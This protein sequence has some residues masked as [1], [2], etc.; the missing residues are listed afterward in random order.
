[1][2]IDA[3]RA[4]SDLRRRR[5][6]VAGLLCRSDEALME[7]LVGSIN[8][9]SL[10]ATLVRSYYLDGWN[11]DHSLP[12]M[13]RASQGRESKALDLGGLVLQVCYHRLAAAGSDDSSMRHLFD[14]LGRE[15]GSS[16]GVALTPVVEPL[17]SPLA[18]YSPRSRAW[19]DSELVNVW[20]KGSH[21]ELDRQGLIDYLDVVGLRGLLN[22]WF[23]VEPDKLSQVHPLEVLS[24]LSID[25]D[26][27]ESMVE[28]LVRQACCYGALRE[29]AKAVPLVLDMPASVVPEGFEA[30][31]FQ[32]IV[33][34]G[35]SLGAPPDALSAVGQRWGLALFDADGEREMF[36]LPIWYQLKLYGNVATTV[37]YD[38]AI[39]LQRR[40]GV[41][42]GSV[43]TA[44]PPFLFLES[45]S[46]HPFQILQRYAESL[47]LEVVAEDLGTIP[48]GLRERI[49]RF[50]FLSMMVPL[51]GDERAAGSL[52]GLVVA[53]ST[54]DL[55]TITGLLTGDD[56]RELQRLGRSEEAAA[57]HEMV[58]SLAA[59]AG[60]DG[61][62]LLEDPLDDNRWWDV[63]GRLLARCSA[64]SR[65][66][67]ARALWV[68]I[69]DFI[70]VT[71]RVNIPGSS[72]PQRRN[73]DQ[74]FVVDVDLLCER[75]LMVEDLL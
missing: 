29:M 63:V 22:A 34:P 46:E 27:F 74:P 68:P 40:Y 57:N 53:L 51:F 16:V 54:H 14:R 30:W 41:G 20:G 73:W 37:R 11:G 3:W 60:N 65:T 21:D 17:R 2:D 26:D 48:D 61:R 32:D 5:Q 23:E 6:R 8:P 71:T 75:L 13:A 19:I 7:R 25:Q 52:V 1:M 56:A 35:Y 47:K 50:G 39:A 31:L 15:F 43:E 10:V 38:H 72:L 58:L 12:K 67:G 24:A 4:N 59:F 9:R 62:S 33:V 66:H 18:P 70:G 45:S 28:L 42:T 69:E 44:D 55:P 49:R 64:R 36:D